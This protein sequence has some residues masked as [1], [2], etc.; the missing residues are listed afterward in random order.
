MDPNLD[1]SI[2]NLPR[3]NLSSTGNLPSNLNNLQLSAT[4]P[5]TNELYMQQQFS[6]I[7]SSFLA[8]STSDGSS[9]SSDNTDSIM[10]NPMQTN[11]SL[12]NLQYNQSASSLSASGLNLLNQASNIL[13]KEVKYALDGKI[14]SGLV[15]SVVMDAGVIKFKVNDVL[16]PIDNLQQISLPGTV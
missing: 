4:D 11:N 3:K 12:M 8:E 13:G 7:F 14:G 9:T 5:A 15:Q 6:N 1:F 10:G 2:A 16:V